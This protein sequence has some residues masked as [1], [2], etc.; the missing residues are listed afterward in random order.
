MEL[1]D[2]RLLPI[3][4]YVLITY[5]CQIIYLCVYSQAVL[6]DNT[7][8]ISGCLGLDPVSS[9]LVEGG[10]EPEANQVANKKQ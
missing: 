7:M 10:I 8:Y 1:S 5:W 9:N 3:T 6:V 4:Y 2:H